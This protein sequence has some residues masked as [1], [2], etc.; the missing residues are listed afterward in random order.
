MAANNF[1]AVKE[2][3]KGIYGTI[4]IRKVR[5]MNKKNHFLMRLFILLFT[6][7]VSVT[8]LPCS[9]I[10]ALGLFG[11]VKSSTVTEDNKFLEELENQVYTETCKYKRINI[12][13]IWYELWCGILCMIFALY[14]GKLPRGDTIITLKVRMDN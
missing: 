1:G 2:N 10:Y 8:I 3:L 11:E 4:S 14:V 13:N 12:I 5:N 6:V 7:S 9:S